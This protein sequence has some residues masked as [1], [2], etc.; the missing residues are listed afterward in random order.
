MRID[1]SGTRRAC[2]FIRSHLISIAE[3]D[4]TGAAFPGVQDHLN[5]CPECASL[6]RQFAEAW[7]NPALSPDTQPSPSFFPRLIERIEAGEELWPGQRGVLAI[8]WRVLR[9]AALAVIFLGGIFAGHELGKRDETIPPP[10]ATFAAQ[11][12]ENFESI[13]P[14]SVADFYVN[15]QNSKREDLE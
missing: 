9:P 5:S 7:E 2:A 1:K 14:G 8:A 6:I 4:I 15:R 12:L 3:K 10:E 13:P 11:L